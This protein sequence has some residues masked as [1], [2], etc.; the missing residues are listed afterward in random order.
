MY[1]TSLFLVGLAAV[2]SGATVSH[3][4]PGLG[5]ALLTIGGIGMWAGL[6]RDLVRSDVRPPESDARLFVL[7]VAAILSL[8][9]LVLLAVSRTV[10]S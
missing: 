6:A 2:A 4:S 9:S 5:S 8:L 10:G 7:T 3:G 1:L